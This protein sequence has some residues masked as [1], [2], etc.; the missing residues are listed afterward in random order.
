MI[1][2]FAITSGLA[3]GQL[4]TTHQT[5]STDSAVPQSNNNDLKDVLDQRYLGLLGLDSNVTGLIAL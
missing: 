1:M 3:K 4:I 5:A 2:S